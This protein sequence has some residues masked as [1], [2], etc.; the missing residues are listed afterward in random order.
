MVKDFAALP[1][2]PAPRPRVGILGEILVKYHAGANERLIDLIEAEGG[3][4]VVPD[5][6]GFLLYCLFDPISRGRNSLEGLFSGLF[7]RLGVKLIEHM[8][9][10]MREALKGTRF[11]EIRDIRD[12]A[13]QAA[14][15]VS[16]ANQAGEGWLLVAEILQL[17]ES[18]IGNILCVQ[19]FACLP[20]HITGRGILKE[21]RRF[22][23]GV[24]VLAL[25]Y[26][27]SVSNVNQLNRIKLLMSTAR[28]RAG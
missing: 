2:N 22:H 3:E 13:S 27:A 8:R 20:N 19:P 10:P 26:D 12:M 16:P 7:S 28:A 9:N 11:G 4:A 17:I 21:L 15:L 14:K 23:R 6:A 18:G 25:D 5:L 24:N 1:V